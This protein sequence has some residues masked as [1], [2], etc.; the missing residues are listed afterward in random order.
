MSRPLCLHPLAL[1]PWERV[2]LHADR[3]LGFREDSA[4]AEVNNNPGKYEKKG[5][6]SDY[7]RIKAIA[8]KYCAGEYGALGYNEVAAIERCASESLKSTIWKLQHNYVEKPRRL[9]QRR[10]VA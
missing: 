7:G 8:L 4:P 9:Q 10:A 2:F 6:P 5:R 1:S 3:I